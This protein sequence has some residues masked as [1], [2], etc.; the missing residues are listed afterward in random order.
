MRQRLFRLSKQQKRPGDEA[1]A[2][3]A[4]IDGRQLRRSVL[5]LIIEGE[6][7]PQMVERTTELGAKQLAEAQALVRNQL[8]V[9]V[10]P[11]FGKHN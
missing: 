5:S 3:N 9:A 10:I 6:R 7:L 11:A 4:L 8:G 1:L 2:D